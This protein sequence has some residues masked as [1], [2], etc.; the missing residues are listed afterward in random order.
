MHRCPI[1]AAPLIRPPDAWRGRGDYS[2]VGIA[3]GDHEFR[4]P[5]PRGLGSGGTSQTGV[6]SCVPVR[7]C[8]PK[9]LPRQVP[10]RWHGFLRWA[11]WR[12]PP[13]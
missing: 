11:L 9:P 4:P 3:G 10:A 7:F 6:H 13:P 12:P 8:A 5:A 2:R 1:V